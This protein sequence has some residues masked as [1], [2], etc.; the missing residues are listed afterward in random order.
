MEFPESLE[1]SQ[2]VQ[3]ISAALQGFSKGFKG[4]P[5][6]FHGLS[7]SSKEIQDVPGV[8]GFHGNSKGSL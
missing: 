7:R 1:A 2:E 6:V 5:G 8:F 3:R 4:V